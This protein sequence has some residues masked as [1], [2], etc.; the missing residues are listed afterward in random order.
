MMDLRNLRCVVVLAR[1]LSFARAAEELGISQ[2]ALTRAARSNA[3][4][5]R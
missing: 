5:R 4:P 3:I 1:R 2:P